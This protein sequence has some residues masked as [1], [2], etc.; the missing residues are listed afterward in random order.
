MAR[1]TAH[2]ASLQ[3]CGTLK[4]LLEAKSED[5]TKRIEP[6]VDSLAGA[7]LW[8]SEDVRHRV[9]AIAGE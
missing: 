5:L 1:R 7:G 6:L 2:A 9:L 3:V 4:V 8:I